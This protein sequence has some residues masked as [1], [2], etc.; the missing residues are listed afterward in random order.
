VALGGSA[1][2]GSALRH[3]QSLRQVA[4]KWKQRKAL[5]GQPSPLTWGICQQASQGGPPEH[6]NPSCAKSER[7]Y[8]FKTAAVGRK[9]KK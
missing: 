1:V 8:L 2:R 3:R 7:G 4:Q 5:C 9:K 6:T